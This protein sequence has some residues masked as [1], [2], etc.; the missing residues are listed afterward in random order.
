M[1]NATYRPAV[2][3][4]PTVDVPPRFLTGRPRPLSRR[5]RDCFANA[6]SFA[7]DHQSDADT[8]T[9]VH[10]SYDPEGDGW[11]LPHA[12]C[13]IDL[14]DRVVVFDGNWRSFH[15]RDTYLREYH[16]AEWMTISPI[17]AEFVSDSF[18]REHHDLRLYR[19]CYERASDEMR[20][21]ALVKGWN[22]IAWCDGKLLHRDVADAMF[23]E[24]AA[25]ERRLLDA[26]GF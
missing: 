22:A 3:L 18:G 10:G 12:W 13:E 6:L 17:G 16:A 5:N 15:D 8:V 11:P 2:R 7:L 1:S 9:L 23:P 19:V 20:A 24:H 26:G 25:Y 21:Y 14:G 4:L